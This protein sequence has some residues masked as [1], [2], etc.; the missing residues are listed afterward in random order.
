M[1]E[2]MDLIRSETM[3]CDKSKVEIQI[4]CNNG[5]CSEAYRKQKIQNLIYGNFD[6]S[7]HYNGNK[8][9]C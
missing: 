8:I 9:D 5:H 2:Y 7:S 1:N 4:W 6:C 3:T